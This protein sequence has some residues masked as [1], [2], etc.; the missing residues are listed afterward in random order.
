MIPAI[1][2]GSLT[3]A[4]SGRFDDRSDIVALHLDRRQVDGEA[5]AARAAAFLV[6][7]AQ[8]ARR[9]LDRPA[10]QRHDQPRFLGDR[11]EGTRVMLHA[12]R[13]APARQRLE[14]DDRTARQVA[15]RL[16]G[17]AQL[18]LLDRA[19]Q[20]GLHRELLARQRKGLGLIAFDLQPRL[21]ALRGEL[22]VADQLLGVLDALVGMRD[23]DRTFDADLVIA[24]AERR[25]QHA[26]DAL[27]EPGRLRLIVVDPH[28][29]PE[30]VATDS[31]QHVTRAQRPLDPAGNAARI[32]RGR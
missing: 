1:R 22:R 32:G 19:A 3:I 13:V 11:D 15:D 17:E 8:R 18:A 30:F 2:S 23:A 27:G 7:P 21:G 14:R 9:F 20:R 29:D 10:A 12:V 6:P 26:L 24:Q 28:Q 5:H 16:E 31:R 4:L 25:G